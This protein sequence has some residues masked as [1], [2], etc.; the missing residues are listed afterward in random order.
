MWFFLKILLMIT[1]W[2]TGS[3]KICYLILINTGPLV[4]LYRYK[5]AIIVEK[6][7]FSNTMNSSKCNISQ[8]VN[9]IYYIY[10][11]YNEKILDFSPGRH[12]YPHFFNNLIENHPQR[13]TFDISGPSAS[14]EGH[15]GGFV[16]FWSLVPRF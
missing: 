4:F 7:I 3:Y 12:F 1:I 16:L 5:F 15:K 2:V 13:K 11:S 14:W 8:V 9:T 10:I 6:P